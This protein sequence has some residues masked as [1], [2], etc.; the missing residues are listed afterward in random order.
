[1]VGLGGTRWDFGGVVV[2][3]VGLGGKVCVACR[4]SADVCTM[5]VLHNR[6]FK[7]CTIGG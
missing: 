2:L 7:C 3:V 6:S 1:M 4:D 5:E